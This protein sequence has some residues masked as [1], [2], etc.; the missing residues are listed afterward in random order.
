MLHGTAAATAVRRERVSSPLTFCS[1]DHLSAQCGRDYGLREVLQVPAQAVTQD[2]KLQQ[3]QVHRLRICSSA[4]KQ[5][6]FI[7]FHFILDPDEVFI[8]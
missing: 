1:L 5:N 8:S 6:V 7:L 2:R 3:F 4:T